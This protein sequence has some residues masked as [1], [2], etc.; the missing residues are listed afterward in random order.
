MAV[1]TSV[2]IGVNG[3]DVDCGPPHSIPNASHRMA[4]KMKSNLARQE[5]GPA[6]LGDIN[7]S[8]E[9]MSLG[10]TKGGSG[11]IGTSVLDTC[12]PSSSYTSRAMCQGNN[13][14]G[15]TILSQ[16]MTTT[17][18][19]TA[20]RRDSNWT[21]STEGYGSMRSEQSIVSRRCS[22]VSAMSA[23]SVVSWNFLLF[24]LKINGFLSFFLSNSKIM[25]FN[26]AQIFR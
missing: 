16:G 13:V 2:G 4:L 23:M 12:N 20:A 21:N 15:Q 6:L 18:N 24:S 25:F 22:D 14:N 1:V 7:R 26:S 17:N 8:I 3:D 5:N 19:T 9:K 10:G 11:R